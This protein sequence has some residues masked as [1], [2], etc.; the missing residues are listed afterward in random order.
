MPRGPKG[1]QRSGAVFARL[2]RPRFERKSPGVL[3]VRR[4]VPIRLVVLAL[5]AALAILVGCPELNTGVLP[6]TGVDVD[7]G[8]LLSG[9]NLSCG[10][11]ACDVYEY[12]GMVKDANFDLFD[13][14]YVPIND[15][16]FLTP[17]ARSGRGV[18]GGVFPCYGLGTFG[19]L[20]L[21]DGGF[22]P[23]AGSFTY[24]V[25]V[26][27]FNYSTWTKYK[28][29]IQSAVQLYQKNPPGA[30]VCD[31]PWSYATTCTAIEVD[32]I[33]VNA[34]CQNLVQNPLFD[35]SV[36]DASRDGT[37]DGTLGDAPHDAP[38][39]A[40]TDGLHDAHTDATDGAGSDAPGDGKSDVSGD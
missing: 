6:Y 39:D 27:F 11:G 23:D 19:N 4:F 12:A 9:A 2:P 32:N 37:V 38:H 17:D 24:S 25:L 8:D 36:S 15:C 35:C 29:Q 14:G 1:C 16:Q 21:P 33:I 40:P 28:D 31:L 10:T 26:Y 5:V 7:I 18:A 34:T 3:L 13:A 30:A 22:I 20:T